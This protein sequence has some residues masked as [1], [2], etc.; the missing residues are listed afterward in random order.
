ML[1]KSACSIFASALLLCVLQP[2]AFAQDPAAPKK[3][4]YKKV[5]DVELALYAYLPAKDSAA[6]PAGGK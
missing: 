3:F 6:K 1:L 5:K 4:V 2:A